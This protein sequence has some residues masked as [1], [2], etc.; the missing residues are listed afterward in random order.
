MTRQQQQDKTKQNEREEDQK[1]EDLLLPIQANG[2][3]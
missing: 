2:I 1:T 3:A